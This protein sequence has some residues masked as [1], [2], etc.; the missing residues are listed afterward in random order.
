MSQDEGVV[1]S[2]SAGQTPPTKRPPGVPLVVELGSVKG[3]AVPSE[4]PA[5]VVE[6]IASLRL[7]R[8]SVR[9]LAACDRAKAALPLIKAWVGGI[10]LL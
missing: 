2:G 9:E 5:A 10:L 1:V 8:V 3:L 4:Q 6:T 7:V